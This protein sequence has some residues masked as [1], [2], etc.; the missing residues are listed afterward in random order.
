MQTHP[1]LCTC[2]C[3]CIVLRHGASH[4]RYY[5]KKAVFKNFAIFTG[6]HLCWSLIDAGL[7]R[8]SN[9]C[10][11]HMDR[12]VYKYLAWINKYLAWL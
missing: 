1:S 2:S 8:G 11:G 5:N 7:R 6:K 10:V 12:V 3:I 4:Q 9:S